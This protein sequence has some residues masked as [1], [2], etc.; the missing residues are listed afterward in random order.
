VLSA[1]G[2]TAP[3][4]S[5]GPSSLDTSL[6]SG[7]QRWHGNRQRR[8]RFYRRFRDGVAAHQ[9]EPLRFLTLPLP[10]G[11]RDS[12]HAAFRDL[13]AAIRRTYGRFDYLRVMER[14]Q[15]TGLV[16]L[17]VLFFGTYIPQAWLSEAWRARTGYAVVHVESADGGSAGYVAKTLVGYMTKGKDS[18][19][20]GSRG[21]APRPS[22]S[23]TERV[24][25]E[26]GKAK[27]HAPGW[28]PRG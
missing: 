9:G 20:V 6:Q 25:I 21:W 13:V 4:P 19:V 26:L 22:Q 28:E 1:D 3:G 11:D 18:Q 23:L 16:H 17:H 10:A 7:A 27:V 24:L 12:I 14:G 2:S 8:A 5:H 15:R